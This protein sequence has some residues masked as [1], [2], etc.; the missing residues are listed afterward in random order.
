MTTGINSYM[1]KWVRAQFNWEHAE[2]DGGKVQIGS[3]P[4]AFSK[5]DA[6]DTRFQVIF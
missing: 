5:E 4:F 1:N 3:A 6:L 2:F